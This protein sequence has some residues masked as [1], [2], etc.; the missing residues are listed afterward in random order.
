MLLN[1]LNQQDFLILLEHL[2]IVDLIGGLQ[3]LELFIIRKNV[4]EEF[5]I[6]PVKKM[7]QDFILMHHDPHPYMEIPQPYSQLPIPSCIL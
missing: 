6:L 1:F 7:D 5:M 4:Q 2:Q 3:V